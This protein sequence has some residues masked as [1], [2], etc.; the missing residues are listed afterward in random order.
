MVK[1]RN[2]RPVSW[3]KAARKAFDDFPESVQADA[4][5]AL[6]IVADG[7]F[8]SIAK[9]LTALGPGIQ[10][11]TLRYRTDAYR[12]IYAVQF[13]DAVWVVHA[14]QKKSK[15]GI[16]TPKHEIEV[17]LDRIKRLREFLK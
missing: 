12:T 3:I 16:A 1:S 6:T 13:E 9:P 4:L 8:P 7:G 2:T 10:E 14:F 17:A 5:T 15:S 11:L